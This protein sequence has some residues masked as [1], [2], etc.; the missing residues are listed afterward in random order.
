MA[1]QKRA[2]ATRGRGNAR[3]LDR[4]KIVDAALTLTREAGATAPSMRQVAA[5][6]EVDVS[7]LYWHF[8]NKAALLA[9]AAGVSLPEPV[10]TRA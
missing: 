6:L 1:S 9:D 3:Q 4:A 7:A 8:P 5:R 10:E 2:G